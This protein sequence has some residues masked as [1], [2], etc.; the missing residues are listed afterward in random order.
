MNNMRTIQ[1]A[2]ISQGTKVLIRLDLDVPF[3]DGKIVETYRLDA[4]LETL[5][6]IQGKGGMPVI[7]GHLG[8]PKGTPTEELST[9]QLLHYFE[10]KLGKNT[11]ELLE[12]LRFDKREEENSVEYAKELASKGDIFVN[13]SFATCHRKHT[14]LVGIPQ[15]LPSYAGLR[16]QKEI[17]IL[18]KIKKDAK[19]PFVVLIGGAKLE[20]KKPVIDEFLKI[21]TYV[22]V[23]GKLGLEWDK[24]LPSNLLIPVDYARDN[25]DIGPKTIEKYK[26]IISTANTLLWAGPMGMYEES[27]FI[28]G[29][30]EIAESIKENRH[31]WSIIGGGDTITAVNTLGYLD[32][33]NFI[34]T[35]GGAM[36]TFLV[37][38]TL[39]GI[40]VLKNE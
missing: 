35:G 23:G 18:E 34:S 1:E 11:F 32:S 6:Y 29:T 36:L 30:K 21:A 10:E 3:K 31:L 26:E 28:T 2:T 37:E 14:S 19:N 12:N 40:E 13:E 4:S 9:K 15:I 8:Q 39:P 5:K 20:S 27:E 33:F 38:N 16:L 22:L 7:I 25:K 17:T 24:E